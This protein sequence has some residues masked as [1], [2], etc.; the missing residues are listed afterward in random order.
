MVRSRAVTE[1]AEENRSGYEGN[2]VENFY[3]RGVGMKIFLETTSV[4]R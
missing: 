4:I 1:D 2:G 3:G